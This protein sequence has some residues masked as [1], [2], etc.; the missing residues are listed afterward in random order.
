MKLR[1]VLMLAAV[2][3]GSPVIAAGPQNV[4]DLA[5]TLVAPSGAHVYEVRR[6]TY[7]VKN[8]GNKPADAARL[9][10][11][12]PRTGTSPEVFVMGDV[13]SYTAGCTLSGTTLTC[14][15]GTLGKNESRNL[16]VDLRLPYSTA[17][18]VIDALA[19][20]TTTNEANAANNRVVHTAALAT[21]PVTMQYLTPV[22]HQHCTGNLSLTS[23]F[24]C[25]L[26]PSSIT[27]HEATF[28]ADNTITFVSAPAT[29]S[30]TWIYRPAEN[31]LQF[32]YFDGVV[33]VAEFDGRGVGGNCFEGLTT[34]PSGTAGY[35]S[36]YR[37]CF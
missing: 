19:S 37:I 18:I 35:Q 6:Y 36:L 27:E 4:P 32:T 17:P 7:T 33:R 25:A 12:L 30:G 2:L 10:I 20:T 13:T 23:F 29:Y 31:R 22:V 9:V 15:L 8:I 11:S 21:Y 16:F 14:L 24:E 34:F 3:A 28:N 5:L 26:F 1:P